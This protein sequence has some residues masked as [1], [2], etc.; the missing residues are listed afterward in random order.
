MHASTDGLTSTHYGMPTC[1]RQSHT[2]MN[3]GLPIR[4]GCHVCAQP[5]SFSLKSCFSVCQ[6]IV[7][8][9]DC[10]RTCT[11]VP[12]LTTQ[13]T[14]ALLQLSDNLSTL[15]H[16]AF[17]SKCICGS[18]RRRTTWTGAYAI[19]NQ[20][21]GQCCETHTKLAQAAQL[22]HPD[23]PKLPHWRRSSEEVGAVTI[24]CAHLL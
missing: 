9:I 14:A 22:L 10:L 4:H 12:A 19:H 17:R 20:S 13:P 15:L 1:N 16:I 21:L 24:L 11:S 6:A 5:S 8:Q 7:D 18:F 3:V 23:H 2:Y